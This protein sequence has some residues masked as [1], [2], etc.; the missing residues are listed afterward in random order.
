MTQL[1]GRTSELA[2]APLLEPLESF[3]RRKRECAGR[4]TRS[5][6][7]WFLRECTLAYETETH[8]FVHA[9]YEP[10][11]PIGEQD[12][13]TLLWKHLNHG[14]PGPHLSG[15]TVIVGHTPQPNG[16]PLDLGH[17][18]C[19]DTHCFGGGWLTAFDVESKQ[20]WQANQEGEV[21]EA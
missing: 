13:I 19:L 7:M 12:E 3:L 16:E 4:L 2:A 15:K 9:N 20:V 6:G 21:K 5:A 18:I 1:R 11:L 17:L 10:H 14:I 8:L